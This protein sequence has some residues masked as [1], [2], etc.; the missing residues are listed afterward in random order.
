MIAM[1]Y[2]PWLLRPT[3]LPQLCISKC[4]KM[5]RGVTQTKGAHATSRNDTN[6]LCRLCTYLAVERNLEQVD[7]AILASSAKHATPPV[8]GVDALE[9]ALQ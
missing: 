9:I 2:R 8:Y 1:T 6:Y 3:M 4:L 5:H 7:A